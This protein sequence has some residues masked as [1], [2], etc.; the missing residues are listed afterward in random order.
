MY[1]SLRG[2]EKILECGCTATVVAVQGGC[3]CLANV[4]DSLAVLAQDDGERYTGQYITYKHNGR[5]E[6][7]RERIDSL[8]ASKTKVLEVRCRLDRC[9]GGKCG[10]FVELMATRDW[11]QPGQTQQAQQG[12]GQPRSWR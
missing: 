3:V 5:D 9:K 11:A 8:F 10:W 1:R 12:Q 2:A 6:R 7:E 4:G